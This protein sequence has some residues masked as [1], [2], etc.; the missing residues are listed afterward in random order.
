[1]LLQQFV[2]VKDV[3]RNRDAY[4][5]I[6]Y[7]QYG[8]YLKLDIKYLLP[9]SNIKVMLRCDHCGEIYYAKMNDYTKTSV[10]HHGLNFCKHC[11][12]YAQ[13]LSVQEKY[14]VDNVSQLNEVKRKKEETCIKNF[15]VSYPMQS[16]VVLEKS[17]HTMYDTYGVEHNL[18]RED[19]KDI[20]RKANAN[21]RGQNGTVMSSKAQRYLCQL[22]NGKLNY[23]CGYYN[24]DILLENN[25]YIEYNGS[26]HKL[27]VDIGQITIDEFHKKEMIRYYY[28]KNCGYKCVIIDN[29]SDKLPS[30]NTINNLIDVCI[31][32]LNEGNNWVKCNFDTMEI[33]TK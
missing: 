32:L 30:D 23:P 10:K 1:M 28:V 3:K 24:L 20:V 15:G 29:V 8:K 33:I 17:R 7:E 31:C 12:G 14:N 2:F 9:N 13:K 18:Q 25:I 27:N 6:P 22:L 16:D 11:R 5:N 26:G 19:I 21:I 4:A